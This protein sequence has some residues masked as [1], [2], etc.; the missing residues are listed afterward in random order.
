MSLWREYELMRGRQERK[1]APKIYKAIYKQFIELAERIE[2]GKDVQTALPYGEL[3]Q[4]IQNLYVETGAYFARWQTRELGAGL[5]R[6]NVSDKWVNEIIEYF[7][8][9]LLE[10]AVLPITETT[11]AIVLEIMEEATREG[12]GVDK[13]VARIKQAGSDIS[14]IR[15]KLIVRTETG[16]AANLGK[17]LAAQDFNYE[18]S[19]KWI[20]AGD[21]R[22]R[23][24]T[25]G[26]G[27]S[28]TAANHMILNGEVQGLNE[29]FSNGLQF[30]G[31]P[32]GGADE[33]CNCRC[34]LT[35]AT[36]KDSQGDPIPKRRAYS[37]T[38]LLNTLSFQN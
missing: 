3:G 28:R 26:G 8:M 33:V 20:T 16:K 10:Q 29:G 13:T 32:N 18:T 17:W 12:W 14:R 38:N 27:I 2:Q 35:F 31:D 9:H 4:T 30:P 23:P 24:Q 19:K 15:T 11:K 1:H 5:K 6:F 36:I 37:N 34:T 22:V 25:R 7:R 21:H